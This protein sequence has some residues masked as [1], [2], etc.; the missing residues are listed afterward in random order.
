[1]PLQKPAFQGLTVSLSSPA[2]L[3]RSYHNT[4]VQ[5]EVDSPRAG[6]VVLNDIWHPWWFGSIDGKPAE[7][8]HANVLFRAI[9]VPAGRHSVRF[10]FKPLEGAMKEIGAR[11]YG[12]QPVEKIA[13]P[14]GGP[15]RPEASLPGTSH[16]AGIAT[17]TLR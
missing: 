4:E 14:S 3:L 8:L 10:E 13:V 11:M 7:I 5:I 2:I 9:Q 6:F 12:K 15:L 16:I 1:M 17:G